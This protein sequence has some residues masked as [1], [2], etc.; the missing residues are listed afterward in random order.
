M[1]INPSELEQELM[2]LITRLAES[3]YSPQK[4]SAINLIPVIFK[5]VSKENKKTLLE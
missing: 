2:D 3:E 4:Q 1:Q 5:N